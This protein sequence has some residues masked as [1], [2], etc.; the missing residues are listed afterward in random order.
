[1]VRTSE[2]WA[3]AHAARGQNVVRGG[4]GVGVGDQGRGTHQTSKNRDTGP[5]GESYH[6]SESSR[7]ETTPMFRGSKEKRQ[8]NV[9]TRAT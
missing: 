7:S 9:R 8:K 6:G 3:C 1:M 2:E 4:F 5:R